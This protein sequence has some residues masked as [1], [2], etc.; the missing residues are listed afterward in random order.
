M[1]SGLEQVSVL[2]TVLERV[3]A[4]ASQLVTGIGVGIGDAAGDGDEVAVGARAEVGIGDGVG[5]AVGTSASVGRGITRTNGVAVG[6]AVGVAVGVGVGNGVTVG[7]GVGT[8]VGADLGVGGCVGAGV[9]VGIAVGCWT[10][11][12]KDTGVA[13]AMTIK[14]GFGAAVGTGWA[15]SAVALGRSKVGGSCSP[16]CNEGVVGCAWVAASSGLAVDGGHPH[17]P[18]LR[19]WAR[20]WRDRYSR[21]LA[22]PVPSDV[23]ANPNSTMVALKS[24][25]PNITIA[26]RRPEENNSASVDPWSNRVT[27]RPCNRISANSRARLSQWRRQAAR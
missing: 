20:D 10:T 18:L 13:V 3:K 22:S 25:L 4:L 24:S 19:D 8:G 16:G 1:L 12:G 9:G 2:A 7:V 15:T 14:V 5:V 17:S 26:W 6:M 27:V 21:D 23:R 11:V